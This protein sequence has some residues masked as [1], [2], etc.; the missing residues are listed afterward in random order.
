MNLSE[1]NNLPYRDNVCCVVFCGE[2]FLLL[3]NKSWSTDWWKFPQGGVNEGETLE[4][5]AFRE[6]KEET[7]SDD[8]KVVGTSK[9][10]NIYD[11]NDESVK[12]A[13]YRWRGQNQKYL[14]VEYL[15]S[16]DDSII[17][18][19][20]ETQAYKWVTINDLWSSIDHADK[21]FTNYK[22]T[23]EKVLREFDFIKEYSAGGIITKKVGNKKMVLLVEHLSGTFVFPKGHVKNGE[24]FED[25]AKREIYEEVGLKDVVIGKQLGVVKRISGKQINL[26]E[27]KV[28]NYHQTKNT[29]ET[30][31]W[32]DINEVASHLRYKED[33]DFF[34]NI[35]D[36]L[37]PN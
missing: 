35:K 10:F 14:L 13:D 2:K 36:S 9:Y 22:N 7:G 4:Q 30:Y 19:S 26:F 21:N 17:L 34:L 24:T 3:Q 37:L 29:D 11:W 32:F 8:F 25:A 23:I 5:A 31:C 16:N 1:I 27:V 6:L 15:G 28:N 20:N 12:L 33:K 18:D